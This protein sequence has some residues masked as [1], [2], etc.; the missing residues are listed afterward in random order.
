VGYNRSKKRVKVEEPDEEDVEFVRLAKKAN[1]KVD[2]RYSIMQLTDE[3]ALSRRAKEEFKT[4]Q[5]KAIRLLESA[6]EKRLD[7]LGFIEA[8]DLM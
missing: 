2:L 8:C 3:L 1:Q 6:Y 5:Q 7:L 4:T